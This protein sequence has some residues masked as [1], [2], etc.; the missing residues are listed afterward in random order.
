MNRGRS[1]AFAHRRRAETNGNRG[2]EMHAASFFLIH[3]RGQ[4]LPDLRD[5]G[6]R[7]SAGTTL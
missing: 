7:S 5:Q 4:K 2:D 6:V 1:L 3:V